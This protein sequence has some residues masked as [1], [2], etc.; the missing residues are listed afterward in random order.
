MI[1]LKIIR[2][3]YFII[4]DGGAE[5]RFLNIR[6]NTENDENPELKHTC[7]TETSVDVSSAYA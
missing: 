4:F 1:F 5:K 7:V 2:F 6:E 3:F